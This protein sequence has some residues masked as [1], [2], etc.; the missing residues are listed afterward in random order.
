MVLRHEG[1]IGQVC[2]LVHMEEELQQ[3]ELLLV[4]LSFF[5]SFSDERPHFSQMGE[6]APNNCNIPD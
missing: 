3:Q 5:V 6:L 1:V 2:G 4:Y